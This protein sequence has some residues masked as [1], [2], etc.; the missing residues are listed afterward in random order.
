EVVPGMALAGRNWTPDGV[1][2]LTAPNLTP[3]PETGA[4]GTWS[5]DTLA[6]A[7]REGIGHDGRAL[8]IMPYGRYRHMTDEDL[9]SVIVY[10]R[11]LPPVK[12]NL[13]KTD[14][15]FPLKHLIKS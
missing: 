3:D 5:D 14:M 15:P 10:L 6:R 2:F 7:I 8:F 12:H 11:S 1:P 4:A 9:A 13:S